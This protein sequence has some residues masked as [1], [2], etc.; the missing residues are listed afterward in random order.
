LRF[1]RNGNSTDGQELKM[2]HPIE[3]SMNNGIDKMYLSDS[4]NCDCEYLIELGDWAEIGLNES[5]LDGLIEA[6]RKLKNQL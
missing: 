5:E 1:G 4:G 3:V 6:L 2:E